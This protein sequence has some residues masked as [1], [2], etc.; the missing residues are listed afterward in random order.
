M[1][2]VHVV[3]ACSDLK[4]ESK[5]LMED[6]VHTEERKRILDQSD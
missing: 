1:K 4:A 5:T 3:M 6:G 2:K